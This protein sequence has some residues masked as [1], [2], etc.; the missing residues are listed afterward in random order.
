MQCHAWTA[1]CIY[2]HTVQDQTWPA[3]HLRPHVVELVGLFYITSKHKVQNSVTNQSSCWMVER[4]ETKLLSVHV[5]AVCFCGVFLGR[6]AGHRAVIMLWVCDIAFCQQVKCWE[7][8]YSTL[9][10]LYE[11]RLEYLQIGSGLNIQ[12]HNSAK[13][14]VWHF[15]TSSTV[16]LSCHFSASNAFTLTAFCLPPMTLTLHNIFLNFL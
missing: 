10:T 6:S 2:A 12:K 1:S 5:R 15:L 13:H 9:I 7:R 4:D 8:L 14:E 16:R 11:L 3:G